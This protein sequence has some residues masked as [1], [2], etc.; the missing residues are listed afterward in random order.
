MKKKL[1]FFLLYLAYVS[2]AQ[3]GIGNSTPRGALDINRP[4]T[5]TYG[6]VLPI[7]TSVS[8]IQNP[9]GGAV[10]PATTIYESSSDCI[11][12]FRQSSWSNCLLTED[13]NVHNI[14]KV[15]QES[16]FNGVY[17][18]GV[19]MTN[20]N[21]YVIGIK[22]ES[23]TA[24]TITLSTLDLQLSGVE[25]IS[26]ASVAPTTVTIQ[27]G[28]TALATY[29]LTGTPTSCGVLTGTWNKM[30]LNHTATVDVLINPTYQCNLGTWSNSVS[31]E[32]RLNGLVVGE[33]YTGTY[34]IPYINGD[35]CQPLPPE[36]ITVNG[37]T[38]TSEGGNLNSSGQITYTLSGTYT[39]S[40][41]EAQATFITASGCQIY[42]GPSSSCKEI[43][44]LFP[45]TPDGV[46]RIDPDKQ[47]RYFASN[48][49]CDMTTDGGGWT[50][51]ANYAVSYAAQPL[52]NGNVG[53]LPTNSF[54]NRFPLIGTNTLGVNEVG[55]TTTFGSG[56][57]YL[58]I[59]LQ[60]PTEWRVWAIRSNNN[61]TAIAATAHY[62]ARLTTDIQ[63]RMVN[64]QSI[65]NASTVT[66]LPGNT[67]PITSWSEACCS[68]WGSRR[69]SSG[70]IGYD[71][72]GFWH[73]DLQINRTNDSTNP[74]AT[75]DNAIYRV[76]VR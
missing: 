6:L 56:A 39:G 36:T 22:N 45:G 59:F 72:Y 49:Q 16:T 60:V 61:S 70:S 58:N 19:A 14:S 31:P 7:N 10:A 25:G 74:N 12:Y 69:T 38:L 15:V 63:N 24:I 42:L 73:G 21:T 17:K 18:K 30:K 71:T 76:W 20:A 28:Q 75:R 33:S 3:V 53:S 65:L 54:T 48:A 41:S 27:P 34:T 50:L 5:N 8:N 68:A 55:N 64:H 13:S 9:R 29:N 40:E 35:S 47:G 57:P 32:H 46:Y 44:E 2:F 62:K 26:V 67:V 37:L 66:A 43:L 1:S 51:L 4:T 52:A 23:S 11:R